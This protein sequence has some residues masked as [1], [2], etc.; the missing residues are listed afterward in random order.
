MC[1]PDFVSPI[2]RYASI[3]MIFWTVVIA[4]ASIIVGSVVNTTCS[5]VFMDARAYLITN[6]IVMIVWSVIFVAIIW[7]YLRDSLP[8]NERGKF[9]MSF[10]YL[11]I[12]YIVWLI[13]WNIFGY[14]DIFGGCSYSVWAM[15]VSL[16]VYQ[17]VSILV[18]VLMMIWYCRT[19]RMN[20]EMV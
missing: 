8:T 11:N 14:I 12:L 7:H 3:A 13:I 4:A 2:I 1:V 16:V 6:G 17:D 5:S 18:G 10:T 9:G 19:Q 20:G 15:M